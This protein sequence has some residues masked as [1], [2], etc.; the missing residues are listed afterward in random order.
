VIYKNNNADLFLDNHEM[1]E[2]LGV[3]VDLNSASTLFKNLESHQQL[4]QL[5]NKNHSPKIKVI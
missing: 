2:G 5:R 3:K 1:K 4:L